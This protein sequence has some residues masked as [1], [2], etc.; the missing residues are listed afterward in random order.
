MVLVLPLLYVSY[1]HMKV[2]KVEDRVRRRESV[3]FSLGA[4]WGSPDT[5][6]NLKVI[7]KTA[8]IKL[9]MHKFDWQLLHKREN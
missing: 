1:L 9:P 2:D 7:Y 4:Q 3:F 8:E 5:A 6:N